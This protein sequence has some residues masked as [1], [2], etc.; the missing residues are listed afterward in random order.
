MSEISSKG[1]RKLA[2]M[3]K[4][5]MWGLKHKYVFPYPNELFDA[6]RPYNLGGFPAS[7]T[8]LVN[9][10]CN[11]KCY[12][13]AMLMS[14]AFS[15]SVV[16]HA[17]IETLRITCGVEH[18][19]HAF[20]E[21]KEF[22]RNRTWVVDTSMG[23]I[24]DKRFYYF[25]EKPKVNHTFTKEQ[26]MESPFVQ[27]LIVDNF[28]QDK[29]ALPI[30]L[31]F[32]ETCVDKS[33]WLSTTVYRE[34]IKEEIKRFKET[35]GYDAIR[36]EIDND[37]A[38][39]RKDPQYVDKRLGIVRDRFGR[40]MS[41]NGVPNPYYVS[42]EQVIADEQYYESIK[43]DKEKREAYFSEIIADSSRRCLKENQ[44]L[45]ER[46]KKRLEEILLSP[47]EDFYQRYSVVLG[48]KR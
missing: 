40:E 16:V 31:P 34:K 39:L 4:M 46:T 14:L 48:V 11:G 1:K 28:E 33:N 36:A 26:L 7:I 22:G 8:L 25:M 15:D 24:Y 19:E 29:Y 37:L 6:L 10:L 27:E 12:D 18:S 21:T 9:E 30:Y 43:D 35:I 44:I 5:L 20:V 13:R 45:A 41:R 2:R 3:N 42:P 32:I 23:L 47:T 17:D 38:M